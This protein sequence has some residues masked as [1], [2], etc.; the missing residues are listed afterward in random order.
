MLRM[1]MYRCQKCKKE[2]DLLSASGCE[3]D[4]GVCPHCGST[5]VRKTGFFDFFIG[6]LSS[7]GG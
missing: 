6:F 7:G 5:D 2:F 4:D 1:Y 3:T